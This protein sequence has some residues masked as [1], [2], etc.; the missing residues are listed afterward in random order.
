[1]SEREAALRRRAR[2][3]LRWY[4]REWRARYGEEFT[5]LL[6]ADFDERPHVPVRAPSI[7]L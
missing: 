5:E 6:M 3:A 7:W 4:P 2:R 1:M